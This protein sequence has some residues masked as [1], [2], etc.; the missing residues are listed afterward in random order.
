MD[1]KDDI[2]H[3]LGHAVEQKY[4]EPLF[5]DQEIKNEYFGKIKKLKN[6]II[7]EGLPLKKVN[8][9]NESY[10]KEF[11]DYLMNTIGYDKLRYFTKD[12]FLDVYSITSLSEYF[13]TGFED[14]FSGNKKTLKNTCPILFSK[15]DELNDLED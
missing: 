7:F 2:I 10:N 8:F 12:L 4:Y 3:E 6:Y 11:D 9:F 1:L 13:A 14:Y 15:I 5:E